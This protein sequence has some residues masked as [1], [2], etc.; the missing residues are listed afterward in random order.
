MEWFTDDPRRGEA[1]L[2]LIAFAVAATIVALRRKRLLLAIPCA[3]IWL[4]LAATAVP[5]YMPARPT[6][7]RN[8]CINNLRQIQDAKLRWASERR[9]LASDVPTEVDLYG[10]NGTNGFLRH[11]LICPGGGTYSYRSVAE[12]PTCSLSAK[13]HRLE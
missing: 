12:N 11:H 2:T 3:F 10:S 1:A 8:A 6:T 13:G 5:N 4:L 7:H 9:K